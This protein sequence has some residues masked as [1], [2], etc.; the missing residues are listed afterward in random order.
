MLIQPKDVLKDEVK[1]VQELKVVYDDLS[2]EQQAIC[3][4]IGEEAYGK[5]VR[6]FGGLSLYI[7]KIDTIER[8]A[9]DE[10]IRSDFNGYNFR[11]LA[12]KYNLS[13]RTIRMIVSDILQAKK[14]APMEG[15]V[16]FFDT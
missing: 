10:K 5:L 15:Q 12:L 14:S 3:D 13:E 2:S 7:A 1:N 11:Y 6:R 4:C 8:S 9:R 16:T